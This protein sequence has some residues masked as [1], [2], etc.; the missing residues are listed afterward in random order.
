MIS[1]FKAN[2]WTALVELVAQETSIMSAVTA[3]QYQPD[4]AGAVAI[5]VNSVSAV[6]IGNYTGA[7]ITIEDL[8]DA[9]KTI[10]MNQ[11]KYFGFYVDSVDVAQSAAN[12]RDP[13]ITQASR[14][15]ALEADKYAFGLYAQAGNIVESSTPGTAIAINSA[16]VE[17]QILKVKETLDAENAGPDRVLVIPSTLNTKLTLA[18]IGKYIVPS[19]IY[20]EGYVGRYAGFDI[21]ISNQLTS[22]HALAFTKRAIGFCSNVNNIQAGASEKRFGDYVKGLFVFGATYVW[23]DEVVDLHYSIAAEA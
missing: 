16:N 18:G 1:N 19:D 5:K 8:S 20:T 13:A 21:Y 11:K 23:P 14:Q 9:Q 12:F 2:K 15:L 7:D 4:A 6:T 17:E 3:G 22:G 10:T